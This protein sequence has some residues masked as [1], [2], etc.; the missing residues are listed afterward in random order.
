[1][2]YC[3]IGKDSDVYVVCNAAGYVITTAWEKIVRLG[4]DLDRQFVTDGPMK[5]ATILLMLR[6]RGLTV[7]Q[8]AIERLVKEARE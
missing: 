3:R 1:M 2:S 8:R 6:H 7:P 4:D 5:A